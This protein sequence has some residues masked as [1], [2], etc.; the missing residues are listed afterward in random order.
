LGIAA[1]LTYLFIDSRNETVEVQKLLTAKVEQFASTQS[2]LDSISKVLD[3]KIIEVRRLGG[4]LTELERIKGQLENDKK[5]LGSDLSFSI[6]RYNLKI[7]DYKNFLAQNEIDVQNLRAENGSLRSQ[8]RALEQEK[9]TILTEN[10]GLKNEKAA[11]AKTLTDYSLQ[12]ADLKN[13]V[14]LASALKAV[15]VQILALTAA[16][17]ERRGGIYKAGRIDQLKIRFTLLANSLAQQT[18]KEIYLRILDVTGAVVSDSGVGGVTSFE[19]QEIGYSLRQ[20]VPFEN[21]DQEVNLLFRR[22]TLYKPG[23][24]TVELYAE[25]FQIGNGHFTVK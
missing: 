16:G 4:S 14:N 22:E 6:Q 2:K 3:Q 1:L 10:E 19:G 20:T 7:R 8:A 5:R 11:L 12:N 24:Y 15:D 25:G 18:D 9:Q 13:K 21:N 23:T 17:K